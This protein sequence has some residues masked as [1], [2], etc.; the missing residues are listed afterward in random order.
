MPLKLVSHEKRVIE[1][2]K[3]VRKV[4][5]FDFLVNYAELFCNQLK[6]KK[7][8]DIS[9]TEQKLALSTH[10]FVKQGPPKKFTKKHLRKNSVV[11]SWSSRKPVFQKIA[12]N[13]CMITRY[14][15]FQ[16]ILDLRLDAAKYILFWIKMLFFS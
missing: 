16:N 13:C 1:A 9:T 6:M 12:I 8:S 14:L 11:E 7:R 2:A 4:F 15:L 10:T 5:A 3:C